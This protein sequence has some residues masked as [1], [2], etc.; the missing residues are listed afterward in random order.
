MTVSGRRVIQLSKRGLPSSLMI[1]DIELLA[2]PLQLRL[3][4]ETGTELRWMS[5]SEPDFSVT[6]SGGVEWRA[7]GIVPNSS[8]P[9]AGCRFDPTLTLPPTVNP[10]PNLNPNPKPKPKPTPDRRRLGVEVRGELNTDGLAHIS[11]SLHAAVG[12]RAGPEGAGGC[13]LSDIQV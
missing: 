3:L 13:P 2:K 11:V 6:V 4:R 5:T 7:L 1:G 12:S 9:P 10:N 8:K